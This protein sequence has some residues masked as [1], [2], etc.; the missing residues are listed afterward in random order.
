MAAFN[1]KRKIVSGT[2]D[3]KKDR[4]GEISLESEISEDEYNSIF[5]NGLDEQCERSLRKITM[6]FH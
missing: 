2:R 6:F 1:L 4:E 5:K 3:V